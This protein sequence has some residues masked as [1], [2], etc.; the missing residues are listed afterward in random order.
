VADFIPFTAEVYFRLIERVSEDWW[1]LHLLTLGV[2]LAVAGL[3]WVGRVRFA[4]SLLAAAL[5]WVGATFLIGEYA[6]LNWAGAW[7]GWAF[8][9]AAMLLFVL[10]QPGSATP[11]GHTCVPRLAG[12]ALVVLGVPA[13]PVIALLAGRGWSHAEVFGIHPDPTAVAALGI[14]LIMLRGWRLWIAAVVPAVWC[15]V[16]ALTLQVL[17]APWAGLLYAAL[18]VALFGMVWPSAADAMRPSA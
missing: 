3:A 5:G 11:P 7:F 2:G 6:Q 9:A 4:G 15:L 17:Q 1:P 10:S 16:S 8:L 12:L 13:Y 14:A 18:A